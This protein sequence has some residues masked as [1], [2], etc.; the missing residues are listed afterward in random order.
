MFSRGKNY[1]IAM[2]GALAFTVLTL[3]AEFRMVSS[4]VKGEDWAALADVVPTMETALW[5]LA[6]LS[7]IINIIPILFQ[8]KNKANLHQAS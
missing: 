4:W 2:A 7:I 5:I 8:G 3:A 1:T 6:I